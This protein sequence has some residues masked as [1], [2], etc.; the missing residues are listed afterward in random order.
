MTIS[1]AVPRAGRAGPSPLAPRLHQLDRPRFCRYN[2]N[3]RV[4][5]KKKYY[6]YIFILSIAVFFTTY[7]Y[8][9]N[10]LIDVSHQINVLHFKRVNMI[11]IQFSKLKIIKIFKALCPKKR[12]QL[13]YNIYRKKMLTNQHFYL[14][15]NCSDTFANLR[16]RK[17]N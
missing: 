17:V 13:S 1:R 11:K 15:L 2:K 8:L 5:E 4:N 6:F 14:Y 3:S 7:T 10:I 12:H 9:Y 16:R